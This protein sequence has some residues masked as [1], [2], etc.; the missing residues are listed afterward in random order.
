M[1]KFRTAKSNSSQRANFLLKM[2]NTRLMENEAFTNICFRNFLAYINSWIIT[3][4]FQNIRNNRWKN[5]Y[6]S[7]VR[8]SQP[9]RQYV[10]KDRKNLLTLCSDLPYYL[11]RLTITPSAPIFIFIRA[12]RVNIFSQTKSLIHTR[13]KLT[14]HT[15]FYKLL[16]EYPC[17]ATE[18]KRNKAL[19]Y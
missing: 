11:R 1:Y 3:V 13:I 8:L 12:N 6:W 9:W 14:S 5:K 15:E 17:F 19:K 16:A 18:I 2:Q 10:D 7:P 4:Q